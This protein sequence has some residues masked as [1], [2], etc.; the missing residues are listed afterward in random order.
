VKITADTNI[1]VRAVTRDHPDQGRLAQEA[2]AAAESVAVPLVVLCELAWV[3]SRRYRVGS[4]EIAE[5]IR[6]LLRSPN[7]VADRPAA[8]AGLAQL[9]SGG[10]FADGVI[11]YGGAQLGS[12]AF[13]S[14]DRRAVALL[15]ARGQ[16]A[17]LLA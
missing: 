15:Q 9:D 1:L 5:A 12:E 11:A 14:F 8:E 10:D 7:V 16:S 2:M 17:R 6:R 3:L 4:A 13:V